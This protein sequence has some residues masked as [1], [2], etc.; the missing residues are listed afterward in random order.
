MET[1]VISLSNFKK[2]KTPAKP[3][4][5]ARGAGIGE[6]GRMTAEELKSMLERMT[7]IMSAMSDA[8]QDHTKKL[9]QL[10]E[11]Q[12]LLAM[13]MQEQRRLFNKTLKAFAEVALE[14]QQRDSSLVEE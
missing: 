14:K 13:E 10:E 8:I 1:E 7:A 3:T 4:W 9:I 6:Q 2:R 5:T 12:V 11:D